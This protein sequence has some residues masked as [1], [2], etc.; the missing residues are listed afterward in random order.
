MAQ[1]GGAE[2]GGQ[3]K[4]A[5]GGGSPRRP[6]SHT[7]VEEPSGIAPRGSGWCGVS[8]GVTPARTLGQ[9][10]VSLTQGRPGA[11]LLQ[12]AWPSPGHD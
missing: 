12:A 8:L 3:G 2:G 9:P 10:G 1:D 11:G 5:R 4:G 6:C 7:S